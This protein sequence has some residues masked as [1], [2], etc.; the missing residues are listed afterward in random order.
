MEQKYIGF[1][2]K[3][4]PETL[5]DT[6][7]CWLLLEKLDQVFEIFNMYKIQIET[8][9]HQWDEYNS[10]LWGKKKKTYARTA[11]EE[12]QREDY[13]Q[14]LDKIQILKPWYRNWFVKDMN[15]ILNRLKLKQMHWA[16]IY[17]K[18]L[19]D[20]RSKIESKL[21]KILRN[22]A[23]LTT[24]QKKLL[25][26]LE[27]RVSDDEEST[28]DDISQ[29]SASKIALVDITTP[30]QDYNQ[31]KVSKPVQ[32]Y[33]AKTS[34]MDYNQAKVS[35]P[36]QYYDAKTS[37]RDYNQAKISKKSKQPETSTYSKI[38]N[39]IIGILL[40]IIAFLVIKRN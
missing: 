17:N 33:D 2:E 21:Y 26:Y 34:V 18:R 11:A 15:N 23:E 5:S 1:T 22:V 39:A 31:A 27:S 16:D 35:K 24:K 25:Q 7:F 40:I 32:Y 30:V 14:R 28:D 6:E 10:I 38:S 13:S 4:F 3:M 8:M 20:F 37:V 12:A 36:V 19:E 9:A 29:E